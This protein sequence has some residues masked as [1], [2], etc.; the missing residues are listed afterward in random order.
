MPL[1]SRIT[2]L[3]VQSEPGNPCW[4][5]CVSS[6]CLLLG[7]ESTSSQDAPLSAHSRPFLT[8]DASFLHGSMKT[9]Q[10][11]PHLPR[12]E[13][14]CWA[15]WVRLGN[16]PPFCCS[17]WPGLLSTLARRT[18]TS[19]SPMTTWL[20]PAVAMMTEWCW[21]RPASPRASTTGSSLWIATTTTP[22]LPSAWWRMWC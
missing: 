20:W 19:S 21:G 9:G 2:W 11:A 6:F 10:D 13:L 18:L 8:L 15:H 4:I 14:W 7:A 1:H 17:Q 22:T 16:R 12:T 3:G 5:G